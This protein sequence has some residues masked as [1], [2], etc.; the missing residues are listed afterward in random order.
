MPLGAGAAAPPGAV[1]IARLFDCEI[2]LVGSGAARTI[3]DLAG[4]RVA[5]PAESVE[6]GR[7]V[8]RLFSAAGVAATFIDAAPG[9]GATAMRAGHADAYAK[10]S[11]ALDLSEAPAGARLLAI[12]FRG[13][14]RDQFLPAELG[15][16]SFPR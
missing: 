7:I 11:A 6:A 9:D 8:R 13:A 1:A 3:A 10:V 12:P 5:A 14:V 2:A 16:S 4:K 15:K